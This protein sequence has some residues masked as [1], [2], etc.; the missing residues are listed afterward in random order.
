MARQ[1]RQ[2][3]TGIEIGSSTIKVLMGEF[4]GGE[5]LTILGSAQFP[6]LKVLKGGIVNANAVRDQLMKALAKAEQVSGLDVGPVFLSVTG[7]HIRVLTSVGRTGIQASNRRIAEHHVV[8]AQENARGYFLQPDQRVLHHLD[9]RYLVDGEREVADPVGQVASRLE[10]DVL[11]VYGKHNSIETSCRMV[12][13]ALGYPA[14]DVA[15]AGIAAGFG[16]LATEEMERGA[17]VIDIGAGVTEYVLFHGPGAF[18]CGQLTVGCEHVANDLAIGLRLPMP[19]CRKILQELSQL[20]GTAEMTPDGRTRMREFETLGSAV[21]AIPL[22]TIEQV[23]ELRLRELFDT[24]LSDVR[25]HQ[26][27]SRIAQGI[28]LTGG[29]AL[30]PGIERLAGRVFETP[31]RIGRPHLVCGVKHVATSPEYVT[32]AGLLRWGRISLDIKDSEPPLM[33]QAQRDFKRVWDAFT[34]AFRW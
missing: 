31:V 27:L 29:G 11:V 10:A 16:A 33:A 13:D 24:I 9:R 5:E 22:S 21:R 3:L 34:R 19:K 14:E 18:H 2:V 23:I 1:K 17:L 30:I 26:G 15:F 20:G 32:A 7:G 28:V 25:T 12:Y 4:P 8:N 6:S